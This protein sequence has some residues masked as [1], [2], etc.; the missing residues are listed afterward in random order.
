MS[1]NK[2]NQTSICRCLFV[3]LGE[4]ITTV[5]YENGKP[6]CIKFSGEYSRKLD[7][8][9][10]DA[11][12]YAVSFE[13]GTLT[14]FCFICDELPEL[15]EKLSHSACNTEDSIW[16]PRLINDA[17]GQSHVSRRLIAKTDNDYVVVDYCV[18]FPS[19]SA[20]EVMAVFP[21][22]D[23][24]HNSVYQHSETVENTEEKSEHKTE[25]TSLKSDVMAIDGK[26]EL[27]RH[28]IEKLQ[29]DERRKHI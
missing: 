9:F 24:Y 28:F 15:P 14:D 3:K 16:T 8:D 4:R 27:A 11:W 6:E 20:L 19:D 29:E 23:K 18:C 2:K 17:L 25:K 5:L 1:T 26:T 21:K 22:S 12:I 10:W 7:K 13:S